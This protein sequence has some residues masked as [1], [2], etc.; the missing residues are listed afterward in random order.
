MPLPSFSLLR[1]KSRRP[2]GRGSKMSLF[3]NTT[4][5][6]I[7]PKG[8]VDLK[9]F[10]LPEE[11]SKAAREAGEDAASAPKFKTRRSKAEAIATSKEE[12]KRTVFVG[13]LPLECAIEAKA[14]ERFRKYLRE[15]VGPV[16]SVR[17]RRLLTYKEDKVLGRPD[18]MLL[19][20]SRKLREKALETQRGSSNAYVV[21]DKE[22]SVLKALE[23]NAS[24]YQE[25][26]LRVD[27]SDAPSVPSHKKCIFMGNMALDAEDEDVWKAFEPLPQFTLTQVRI[28]R[29]KATNRGKGFAYVCFA[30]RGM[31]RLALDLFSDVDPLKIKGRPVRISKCAD[32]SGK[33]GDQS[34]NKFAKKPSF[35]NAIRTK[36]FPA[37][38][39]NMNN[40]KN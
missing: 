4:D 30:D 38:R 36:P 21:F 16:E 37:F 34:N 7:T 6:Q 5:A 8:K 10:I 35:N 15:R 27:R 28:V 22:E 39:R 29:D 18:M 2:F 31:V 14:Q 25:H 32:P 26:H 1:S 20:K 9:S 12:L 19:K 24:L 11:S 17:F 33:R 23:L 3:S 13:N 40:N